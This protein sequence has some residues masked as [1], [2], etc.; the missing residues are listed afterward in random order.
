MALMK[1]HPENGT[2]IAPRIR[3]L[4][5]EPPPPARSQGPMMRLFALSILAAVLGVSSVLS[6]RSMQFPT[7]QAPE[8]APATDTGYVES[9]KATPWRAV[10]EKPTSQE[11]IDLISEVTGKSRRAIE[12]SD[13]RRTEARPP[14]GS[15]PKS[16]TD[17]ETPLPT[18]MTRAPSMA[19]R[20]LDK[21]GTGSQ[22][23]GAGTRRS[24]PM[25]LPNT[26]PNPLDPNRQTG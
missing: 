26:P 3:I 21:S 17:S 8:Q 1:E 5:C 15:N 12:R 7:V 13:N 2:S 16:L 25:S 6:I 23:A 19:P 18:G 10:I 11:P 14:T 4:G 20:D 24:S 22:T 9:P